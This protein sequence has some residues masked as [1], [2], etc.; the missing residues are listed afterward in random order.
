[1][2]LCRVG[3]ISINKFRWMKVENTHWD[4]FTSTK[5]CLNHLLWTVHADCSLPI[6][7]TL[8]LYRLFYCL[9]KHNGNTL[10]A[11]WL[12]L[13]RLMINIKLMINMS[14]PN[15]YPTAFS[16][17]STE[18]PHVIFGLREERSLRRALIG[19]R[20]WLKRNMI[21]YMINFFNVGF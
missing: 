3:L 1:M 19:E 8:T 21:W 16:L 12:T 7:W 5:S 11:S 9:R 14:L 10:N 15:I 6:L 4:S 17:M 2:R 20:S 18:N 13:F